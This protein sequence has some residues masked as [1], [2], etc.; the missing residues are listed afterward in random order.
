[1]LTSAGIKFVEEEEVTS[2]VLEGYVI[3][4]SIEPGEQLDIEKGEE[5]VVY[6]A[7]NPPDMT[8]ISAPETSA[9]TTT[10][11]VIDAP[12]ETTV[13]T[14]ETDDPLNLIVSRAAY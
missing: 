11:P 4:T 9:E 10:V 13:T 14:L 2:D 8:G 3:R 5:L 12:P 6:V 7:V 1:M